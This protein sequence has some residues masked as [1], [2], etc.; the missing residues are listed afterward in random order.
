M[1]NRPLHR[2][3]KYIPKFA[4]GKKKKK[5]KKKNL[6][7]VTYQIQNLIL[8]TRMSNIFPISSVVMLIL[9]LSSLL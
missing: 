6:K 4:N 7:N 8:P 2:N 9:E 3:R 5:K 1:I